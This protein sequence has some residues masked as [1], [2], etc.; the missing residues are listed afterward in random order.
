M[1]ENVMGDVIAG[2]C[3]APGGRCGSALVGEEIEG[4]YGEADR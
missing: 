2:C 3:D 1:G 4:E